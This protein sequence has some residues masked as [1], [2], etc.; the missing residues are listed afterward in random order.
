MADNHWDERYDDVRHEDQVPAPELPNDLMNLVNGISNAAMDSQGPPSEAEIEKAVRREQERAER[1][2]D[3][4]VDKWEAA[5]QDISVGELRQRRHEKEK[6]GTTEPQQFAQEAVEPEAEPDKD[7]IEEM[8]DLLK[9][10]AQDV[11]DIKDQMN[12]E[13]EGDAHG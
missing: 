2:A 10:I 13:V 7:P 1:K 3:Y 6:N 5:Q 12:E 11:S 8:V 9:Q 4:E